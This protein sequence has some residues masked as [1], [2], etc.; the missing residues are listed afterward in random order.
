MFGGG[1]GGACVVLPVLPAC[2]FNPMP[3]TSMEFGH[4]YANSSQ[5]WKDI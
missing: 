1:G 4:Y 2:H 5:E 3:T